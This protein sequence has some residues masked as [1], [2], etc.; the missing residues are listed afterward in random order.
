MS[1]ADSW[2]TCK[3]DTCAV[4][5]QQ[6]TCIECEES[7]SPPVQVPLSLPVC[8]CPHPTTRPAPPLPTHIHAYPVRVA[9]PSSPPPLSK[10]HLLVEAEYD[11]VIRAVPLVTCQRLNIKPASTQARTQPRH[12]SIPGGDGA[13]R[14][15]QLLLK[16]RHLGRPGCQLLLQCCQACI[17]GLLQADHRGWQRGRGCARSTCSHTTRNHTTCWAQ[18]KNLDIL[19]SLTQKIATADI[20]DSADSA[21]STN[22]R[23]TQGLYTHAVTLRW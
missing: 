13:L 11:C 17:C 4:A 3:R 2:S 9:A 20:A 6:A 22:I 8:V 1:C 7:V 21:A 16:L 12:L 19:Q 15:L 5:T 10:P 14:L 18:C 23:C